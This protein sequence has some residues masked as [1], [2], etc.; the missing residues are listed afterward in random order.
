MSQAQMQWY[1]F[2]TF[3]FAIIDVKKH[4]HWRFHASIRNVPTTILMVE[5]IL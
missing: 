2:R 3:R 1:K 4:Q 5:H